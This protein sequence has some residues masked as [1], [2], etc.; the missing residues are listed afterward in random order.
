M[1]QFIK[2]LVKHRFKDIPPE[3]HDI[4]TYPVKDLIDE[5]K[6]IYF[7]VY[8]PYK[9]REETLKLTDV[10]KRFENQ[11]LNFTDW[12]NTLG[13]QSLPTLPGIVKLKRVKAYRKDLVKADYKMMPVTPL[14]PIDEEAHI[15]LKTHLHLSKKNI[16][17]R[18]F[19]QYCLVSVCGYYHFVEVSDTGIWVNDGMR[20]MSHAKFNH[21]S[22]ISFKELGTIQTIPITKDM[23]IKQGDHTLFDKTY[24]KLPSKYT[25]DNKVIMLSLG[26]YL[27]ILDWLTFRRTS[28]SLIR[29][30]FKNINYEKRIMESADYLN[31]THYLEIPNGQDLRHYSLEDLRKDET[32]IKYLTMPQSFIIILDRDEVDLDIKPLETLPA[33]GRYISYTKPEDIMMTGHGKATEYWDV[34]HDGQYV[35]NT[36]LSPYHH[37]Q[38]T[39]TNMEDITTLDDKRI[40]GKRTEYSDAYLLEISSTDIEIV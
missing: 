21:A 37:R 29:V 34:Y 19:H 13:N 23:I 27:H 31:L 4:S 35:V 11:T 25:L 39:K 38:F 17:P 18:D 40:I 28:D 26:G 8:N 12:L 14:G 15:D 32:L 36:H 20:T 5:F 33:P 2:A 1:Y 24:L 16:N 10:Y 9:H 30:D 22:V 7:I 6:E 3:E